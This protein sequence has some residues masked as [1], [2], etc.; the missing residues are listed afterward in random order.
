MPKKEKELTAERIL[1]DFRIAYENHKKWLEKANEDLEFLAGKQWK[2]EDVEKLESIKVKALTINKIRPNMQ[3]LTGLESQN[4]SDF[5]AYPE[6]EED[7]IKAEIAT[8]LIKNV[9]KNSD[10]NYVA[11]EQFDEG[12]SIGASF[13]EPYMDYTYDM[14]YGQM[15]FK[16]LDYSQIFPGK[17][18]EYDFNDAPYV[19]KLTNGLSKEE[20]IMLFPDAEDEIEDMDDGSIMLDGIG[21]DTDMLGA[22]IQKT[23]YNQGNTQQPEEELEEKNFDLLEY[24]YKKYITHYYLVDQKLG[25]LKEVESRE[26]ADKFIQAQLAIDPTDMSAGVL[27]RK[28]PE[29]WVAAVVGSKKIDDSRGTFYPKWRIYPILPMYGFKLTSGVKDKEYMIQ[30]IVRMLK[31]PQVEVNKR[32]TQELRHLN[33]SANSGWIAEEDSYVDKDK[34]LTSSAEPGVTLEY[35]KGAQKPERIT[36]TPLSQGHAQLVAE[37]SQDMKEISGINTDLL[38]MNEKQASGRAINLRQKQGLVMVQKLFD[39]FSRTKRAW[40]KFILSQLGEIYDVDSAIKVMGDAFITQNFSRPVMAQ[41]PMTGEEKPQMD[42]QTGELMT[43]VDKQAV[44]TM[45]N[46]ILSDTA[47]GN[48]DVAIGEGVNN[49]TVKYGNFQMLME[50]RGGGIAVP[51]ELI[52]EQ[53]MV[54]SADKEKIKNMVQKQQQMMAEEAKRAPAPKS[55][56][57]G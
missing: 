36:P 5:L 14:L 20:L 25:K 16:K 55:N 41:D 32:R 49:E 47:L 31:D 17:H 6:G 33:Q 19:C 37:N 46:N 9:M 24:Y 45:F 35:K 12:C 43:E 44:A 40:G 21:F 42:P 28:I 2:D 15:K 38:A 7:S 39:N 11:S 57:G 48:Y 52:V 26:I 10:G 29:I 34:W 27:E 30:G 1:K 22:H 53:S 50:M 54:A 18:K 4:R 3:L 51:D 8:S 56:K 13:V 23:D